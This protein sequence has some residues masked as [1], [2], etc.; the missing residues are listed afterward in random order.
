MSQ[1]P[2]HVLWK[3][4]LE[5]AFNIKGLSPAQCADEFVT[6]IRDT[7]ISISRVNNNFKPSG[8]CL[9]GAEE[10]HKYDAYTCVRLWIVGVDC[11]SPDC[12]W[13]AARIFVICERLCERI[14]EL[15]LASMVVNITYAY[16][17]IT[18]RTRN[19]LRAAHSASVNF[20]VREFCGSTVSDTA[21]LPAIS[22][23]AAELGVAE[24]FST[25]VST[26][27]VGLGV[28]ASDILAEVVCGAT[29][30]SAS[31]CWVGSGT[32]AAVG[33]AVS[34]WALVTVG[35]GKDAALG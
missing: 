32:G 26:A 23:L 24:S 34:T 12:D 7:Q 33:V 30:A 14:W 2:E 8:V 21:P 6:S 18:R 17:A 35:S 9:P 10:L 5:S 19:S 28:I 13:S 22:T 1:A 29:V 20:W 25:G 11:H 15:C 4:F 27:A 31:T 3:I 16:T